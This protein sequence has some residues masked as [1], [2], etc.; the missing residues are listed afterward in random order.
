[1]HNEGEA[2]FNFEFAL[3]KRHLEELHVLNVDKHEPFDFKIGR[4]LQSAKSIQQSDFTL[5]A[6]KNAEICATLNRCVL[7]L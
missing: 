1:M 4:L 5:S 7:A 6:T 2:N 3:L